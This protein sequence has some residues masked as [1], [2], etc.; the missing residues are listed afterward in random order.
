MPWE[1]WYIL[2]C[3]LALPLG[4]LFMREGIFGPILVG[5]SIMA[6]PTATVANFDA[7]LASEL[8]RFSPWI[9]PLSAVLL[10][11]VL[12]GRPTSFGVK[13]DAI[14][15]I[16]FIAVFW[17]VLQVLDQTQ[18]VLS[19]QSDQT[20]FH[21]N[22]HDG[23]YA[24][25][26]FELLRADYASRLRTAN[27]YPIEWQTYYFL[28][29][30]VAAN[31]MQWLKQ[32]DLIDFFNTRLVLAA[33]GYFA[34]FEAI[35]LCWLTRTQHSSEPSSFYS[36]RSTIAQPAIQIA[37]VT[38]LLVWWYAPNFLWNMSSS[39]GVAMIA[40][41]LFFY[42]RLL[43][44]LKYSYLWL[45]IAAVAALRNAPAIA[46]AFPFLVYWDFK[47]ELHSLW[48]SRE[49]LGTSNVKTAVS[50]IIRTI[51][52]ASFILSIGLIYCFATL[53][54]NQSPLFEL[55]SISFSTGWWSTVPI[56]FALEEFL[57]GLSTNYASSF[58]RYQNFGTVGPLAPL[59]LF[60]LFFAHAYVP[61]LTPNS[62]KISKVRKR[63]GLGTGI[64]VVICVIL[65][66]F[67]SKASSEAAKL[68]Y[69]LLIVVLPM[70]LFNVMLP[71]QHGR[72]LL[73]L[74]CAHFLISTLTDSSVGVTAYYL[75]HFC[76]LAAVVWLWTAEISKLR[77]VTLIGILGIAIFSGGPWF[78]IGDLHQ[79]QTK[80]ASE[81][82][83]VLDLQE[84]KT[85]LASN[86][87]SDEVYCGT[88]QFLKD[89]AIASYFGVRRGWDSQ[90][91]RDTVNE[92]MTL[93]L[94]Q[95]V[96]SS[97]ANA[98]FSNIESDFCK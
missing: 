85:V 31:F 46:L 73:A 35:I 69:L 65:A 14:S 16:V 91:A 40:G 11:L 19:N 89:D 59:C 52:P 54:Y 95:V 55:P 87:D 64:L 66:Q 56:F 30:A 98:Q 24:A 79:R 9:L 12:Y 82:D 48:M 2:L 68:F 26:P 80:I 43:D 86:S 92:V 28:G 58:S 10:S 45:A 57:S 38:F 44:R 36:I 83:I 96:A 42:F 81:Y 75:I 49:R 32:P 4:R 13:R 67:D 41:F 33:L 63:V 71:K 34:I 61:Q 97:E 27:L 23:Y 8:L 94:S 1:V 29:G 77:L 60:V 7:L 90:I 53:G 76:Y 22:S 50:Q 84:A 62:G 70:Y 21:Y 47:T 74:A 6:I 37:F 18:Y 25:V 5:I 15:V 72:A 88:K 20:Q 51:W 3:L 17:I 93:R 39:G 78:N